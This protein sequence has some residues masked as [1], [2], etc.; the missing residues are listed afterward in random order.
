MSTFIIPIIVV[1]ATQILKLSVD[2]VKGNLVFRNLF[3]E[4]GGMP[5]AHSALVTSLTTVVALNDGFYSAGFG[6]SLIFSFIIIRDAFTLRK[7]L[8]EE[9][10]VVNQIISS[11][12]KEEQKKYPLL[13]VKV[14]HTVKQVL[15]G[16]AW[17]FGLTLILSFLFL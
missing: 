4:Y 16:I 9:G 1:F 15:A 3:L 14:G 7:Y 12:P 5:S 2:G 11:L 17:G 13:P 6:I 10:V 8:G